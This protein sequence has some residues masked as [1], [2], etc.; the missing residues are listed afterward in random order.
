[1]KAITAIA[2]LRCGHDGLVDNRP[3]QD[4]VR[5]HG[6][7]VLVHPD[8]EGR[9]ISACPN[10]G[11]NLKP[12]KKTL[13]VRSG[14]SALVRIDGHAV[15]L[16]TVRGYTDGVPPMAVDYTVRDPGQHLVQMSR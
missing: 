10:V 8:P 14:Y 3:S 13:A 7:S 12:C 9:S 5:I 6:R 15:A 16:E 1:M 11:A 2:V 4:W